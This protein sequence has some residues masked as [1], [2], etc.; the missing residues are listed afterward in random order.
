[1]LVPPHIYVCTV[2]RQI[3]FSRVDHMADVPEAWGQE[4]QQTWPIGRQLSPEFVRFK[5]A[6]CIKKWLNPKTC[7]CLLQ[8]N[9]TCN[10]FW[11][12]L[13]LGWA[14]KC[15]I[16]TIFF[17]I[18]YFSCCPLALNLWFQNILHQRGKSCAFCDELY[19]VLQVSDKYFVCI[20]VYLVLFY[21]SGLRRSCE[22]QFSFSYKKIYQNQI[23]RSNI[24]VYILY[25]FIL[26]VL[27]MW[28]E[29]VMYVRSRM[30]VWC[31]WLHIWVLDVFTA[32]MYGV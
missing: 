10:N 5:L 14:A 20:F 25:V 13:K 24:C 17:K 28:D 8:E 11:L 31:D 3:V 9:H 1:M 30:D 32:N 16:S 6:Y 22:H 2:K 18:S 19:S 15:C 21:K 23:Y 12:F 29:D 26:S 7:L 27:S 4:A